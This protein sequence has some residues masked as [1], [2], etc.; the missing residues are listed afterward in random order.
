MKKTTPNLQEH[1]TPYVAPVVETVEFRT[2][3]GFAASDGSSWD[4]SLGET[5]WGD[6]AE[7]NDYE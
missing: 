4:Q 2:E 1:V 5:T 6:G 7:N 3:R